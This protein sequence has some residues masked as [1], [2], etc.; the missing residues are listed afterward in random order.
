MIQ[1][2]SQPHRRPSCSCQ[3][4]PQ[5]ATSCARATSST[6]THSTRRSQLVLPILARHPWLPCHGAL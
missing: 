3:S 5:I 1:K 4:E 2:E 6:A